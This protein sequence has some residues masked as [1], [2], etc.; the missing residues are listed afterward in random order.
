MSNRE[1]DHLVSL[2]IEVF[3]EHA[4][5]RA[6]ARAL[7]NVAHRPID[8]ALRH[9]IPRSHRNRAVQVDASMLREAVAIEL[10]L[11]LRPQ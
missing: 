5:E 1:F 6:M 10:R 8:P 3:G 4:L 2:V 9:L 11:L 7:W